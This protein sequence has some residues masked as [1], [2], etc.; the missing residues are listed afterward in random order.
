M[1]LRVVYKCA[2][3]TDFPVDW[4]DPADAQQFWVS[5][6]DHKPRPNL[7]IES[8]HGKDWW[9]WVREANAEAHLP[10]PPF[11]SGRMG[12]FNGHIY[13][14]SFDFAPPPGLDPEVANAM[15]RFLAQYG[16]SIG[17]TA[18]RKSFLAIKTQKPRAKLRGAESLLF[19]S[20]LRGAIR[21]NRHDQIVNAERIHAS[22]R[23]SQFTRRSVIA[24][25]W[26]ERE[27]LINTS[28]HR[29]G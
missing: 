26:E 28:I 17:V 25:L 23:A 10:L 8:S 14:A 12:E 6:R 1:P 21:L 27:P 29:G 7:P 18:L 4:E 2:D 16:G 9:A 19:S 3:G 22:E 24:Q 20:F 13:A 15:G 5:M 11:M